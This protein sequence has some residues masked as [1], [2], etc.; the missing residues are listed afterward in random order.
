MKT[1]VKMAHDRGVRLLTGSNFLVA[2]VVPGP[3]LHRELEILVEVGLSPVEA[4]HCST[5]LAA[6]SLRVS[7]RGLIAPGQVADLVIVDGNLADD[8]TVLDQIEQV[9][10][11]GRLYQRKEL[12]EE[13][14][15]LAAAQLE[16]NK[17]LW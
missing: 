1:F 4:I 8:I 7:D 5:G 3:S 10:L 12:L 15:R 14:A 13:A 9:M 17:F 11:A 2:G 16:P 6:E